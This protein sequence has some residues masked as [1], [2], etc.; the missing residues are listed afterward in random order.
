[1]VSYK[2]AIVENNHGSMAMLFLYDKAPK[3][4]A[5][6]LELAEKQ[7]YDGVTFHYVFPNQF[8]H[9][10]CPM[11]DGT[12][13]RPDGVT[14]DP[15]FNDTPFDLGTVGMAIIESDENSASCQFFVC[16][17]RQAGWDG[18]YTAFARIS[19]PESISTLIKLGRVPGDEQHRPLEPVKI[20][21]ITITNAPYLPRGL[22]P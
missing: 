7:F 5:N 16:L 13:K 3:H 15:E 19:G 4:V 9:G 10:G 6:F 8:I 20:N 14:L 22:S 1:M 17:S 21:R 18:R 2:Q 12:G 11:G